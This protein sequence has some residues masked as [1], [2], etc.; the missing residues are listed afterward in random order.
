MMPKS[1]GAFSFKSSIDMGE[2]PVDDFFKANKSRAPSRRTASNS[3]RQDHISFDRDIWPILEEL[4]DTYR[5]NKYDMLL[6]NCN[7]FTD[8]FVRRLFGG[9]K[10]IANYINRAAYIGSFLHCLVPTKYI[11]VIPPGCEEEAAALA[12]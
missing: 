6:K 5:A 12:E 7:H 2:I 1:H 9:K 10:S 11:T 4:M 8:E 3:A